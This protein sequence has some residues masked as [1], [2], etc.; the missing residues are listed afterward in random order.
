M[1][2]CQGIPLTIGTKSNVHYQS[3]LPIEVRVTSN[4]IK[5]SL[6]EDTIKLEVSAAMTSA[7]SRSPNLSSKEEFPDLKTTNS[8]RHD[9][10]GA[11]RQEIPKSKKHGQPSAS[12]SGKDIDNFN[13]IQKKE[14]EN[15]EL[16]DQ[17]SEKQSFKYMQNGKILDFQFVSEKRIKCP[18][19]KKEYK[20]ILLHIQRSSCIISDPDDLGEKFKEHIRVHFEQEIKDDKKKWREKS[21]AKQ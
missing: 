8:K 19:C 1:N 6:P 14:K 11:S 15:P 3:L 21:R 18:E 2:P 7:Q 16:P 17:H 20:N 12:A 13:Q 5:P 9:Q 4:H 10:P